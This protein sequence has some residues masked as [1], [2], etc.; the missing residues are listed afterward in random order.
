V[1][2]ALTTRE[3]ERMIKQVEIDKP[4]ADAVAQRFLRDQGLV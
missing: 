2:A 1:S 4:D 3:L